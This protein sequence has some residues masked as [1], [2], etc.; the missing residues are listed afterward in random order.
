[1]FR[2]KQNETIIIKARIVVTTGKSED[3]A[4][5]GAFWSV[6]NVL[7]LALVGVTQRHTCVQIHGAIY[8]MKKKKYSHLR[9]YAIISKPTD[10]V[11]D[12]QCKPL[13]GFKIV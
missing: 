6:G 12:S 3:R 4:E 13:Q 5:A 10:F 8:I 11:K 7:Y 2:T 1:M 9:V